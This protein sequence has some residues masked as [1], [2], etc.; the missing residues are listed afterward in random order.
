[1]WRIWS[2]IPFLNGIAHIE[3]INH[4]S[5]SRILLFVK[6]KLN[7]A[8]FD[9]KTSPITLGLSCQP[10]L[11]PVK[12]TYT[13]CGDRQSLAYLSRMLLCYM[14]ADFSFSTKSNSRRWVLY[15]RVVHMGL[16][17]SIFNGLIFSGEIIGLSHIEGTV[18]GYFCNKWHL[19]IF[20]T[21][22]NLFGLYFWDR[23]VPSL[24]LIDI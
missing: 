18:V 23:H 6:V 7:K 21:N 20:E 17:Y 14:M 13:F 5:I 22:E 4:L 2:P 12:E 16:F 11:A 24:H 15:G 1:M 19:T 9:H 10:L 8:V 3:H